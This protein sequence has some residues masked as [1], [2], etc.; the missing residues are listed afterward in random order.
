MTQL[1]N[2]AKRIVIKVGSSLLIGDGNHVRKEW[3]GE[4][5]E[6]I[7]QLHRQ[8]KSVIIVTSGAVALGR[9]VLRYGT[10]ALSLEEKQAAAAAGQAPLLFQWV[11]ALQFQL[12]SQLRHKLTGKLPLNSDGTVDRGI[13]VTDWLKPAQILLTA[14][15]LKDRRRYLNARNTLETLLGEA[16][17]PIINENDTVATA[18]LRFGDND[19]LAALVA[20]MAGA[21]LLILLSDVDGLYK[22]DPRTNPKVEF[23]EEIKGGVTPEIEAYASGAGSS[24]GTG[25]MATKLQA[26]K[27]ALAAGCHMIIAAGGETH[28]IERLSQG[29]KHTRFIAEVSPLNARKRWISSML[30]DTGT[31]TIDAG[32]AKALKEGKSLLPAGVT[33]VE[34]QFERGDAVLI[35]A[36][37]GR[38]IAKGLSA[39]SSQDAERIRGRQSFEVETILGFKGRIALVHRDDLVL[40]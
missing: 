33:G 4:L 24:V 32:A 27:I 15:D 6:D 14:G 13:R 31:I 36:S 29:A 20:Q 2:N 37:D 19:R 26:A 10:R 5:A 30:Q 17:I 16:V 34:G 35:R 21:D 23:I 7:L 11:H 40:E 38:M 25:G 9:H 22:G 12:D 28:P 8:D 18:E 1:L 3:L 39:Y